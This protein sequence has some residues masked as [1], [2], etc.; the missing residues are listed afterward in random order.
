[1]VIAADSL[2]ISHDSYIGLLKGE[3]FDLN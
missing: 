3:L 2:S 1:V